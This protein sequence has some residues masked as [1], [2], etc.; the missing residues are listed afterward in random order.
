MASQRVGQ[1]WAAFPFSMRPVTK[2]KTQSPDHYGSEKRHLCTQLASSHI[3][4]RR[5]LLSYPKVGPLITG[6]TANIKYYH[7]SRNPK[8]KQSWTPISNS[9]SLII[10]PKSF[11]SS[12]NYLQK[13]T[14]KQEKKKKQKKTH[15]SSFTWRRE[16][17]KG[18]RL[19]YSINLLRL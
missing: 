10:T 18:H 11:D 9:I 13:D 17:L 2:L 8:Y 15:T 14:L 3:S 12:N 4:G 16:K 1:D 5:T 19:V 6:T 7:E